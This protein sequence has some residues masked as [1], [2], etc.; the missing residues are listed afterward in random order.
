MA[1]K[2]NAGRQNEIA[3]NKEAHDLFMALKYINNG[4]TK[5]IQD[6]QSPIPIGALWNDN[7]KGLNILKINKA[8]GGW[9]PAFEGYYHP[10]NIKE[11]P[12]FPT[13][14]QIWI[15]ESQDSILK[16]YDQ[17]TNSWIATR[18]MQTTAENV[19]VDMHN[20]FINIF[21]LK[22][23]DEAEGK[24]TY[25]VPYDQY[26]KLFDN[27]LFI[28]PTDS[29]Y[30]KLSDVSVQYD[31]TSKEEQESWIHVNAHKVFKIEKKLIKIN[32]AGSE[33][34][35]VYGL[36]DN[37][38]ELYYLDESGQG[39]AMIPYKP[40][41][42][43]AYDYKAFNGGIEIISAKA[44]AATYIYSMSYVFQDT[45]NPGKLIRN[46]FTIGSQSEVQIGQLTKR[47]LIFLDGLYLEQTKYNY[48]SDT[49][50]V[51]INDT[52]IN[53]MD[54]MAVVFQDMESTG[55]KEIN[56]VT[57]P[58]T[59][60]LVGT[61]TNA[62][63]F[64]KPLAFVSGVMGTNVVSPEE[65]A[66]QGTSLVIK[67]WGLDT[68]EAPARVMVV[69]ADNMYLCHGNFDDSCII[70]NDGISNNP[71]D[72][73]LLFIDGLLM[74]SRELDVSE[75]QI[76]IANAKKGQQYVLLK[77]KD[78]SN[79]ALS[80]DN[81]VM[82]FTIAINNEDGTM[83]NECND[84]V[85]FADGKMIP[86]EDSV[87]RD[88]LPIR[89]SSGQIIKVKNKT[90]SSE[91]YN[92]Y[93]W[94]EDNKRWDI[95]SDM[96]TIHQITSFIKGNYSNGSI[97]LDSV[98]L[99][100][101]KGTYYAYTYSNGVEEP[102]LKGIQRL[103]RDQTEYAVNVEHM[104]N[105]NQGALSVY[106][107]K[108]LNFEVQEE[109]S[110]T[111]KFIIPILTSD[112][113][114]DPYENG[115]L[116]YYIERP[117]KNEIVSCEKEVL[118][119]ANRTMDFNGGYT[120]NIS[121]LPGVVNVYVNGVRLTRQDFTIVNEN[122]LIIHKQIVGNQNNYDPDNRDTWNKFLFYEKNETVSIEC[123]R[124]D[125]I[126]VEVRQDYNLK[127]QTIKSRYSGQRTFYTEDDG[128]PKSLLISQDLIK[129]F[130]DG[131]IY[132]G[133]YTINRESGSITLLDPS[134]DSIIGVDPIAR[135]FELNPLEY[136]EY[137]IEHGKPYV[138]NPIMNEITFE[139]R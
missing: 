48:H 54:M 127:S 73:Y 95:I 74:S 124:D 33:A 41:S 67:N 6:K 82:N 16:Y 30:H 27:G 136:E 138:S 117:E 9:V 51:Q 121:L 59:D 52:I 56:N 58:G 61:F 78:N 19:L 68:I 43:K 133:E 125:H 96:D 118:T 4:P 2:F 10:V 85:I 123:N 63:N 14:G 130:I 132:T 62:V 108:L 83:Y 119:A 72:E 110:N 84:A 11:K 13:D 7:G 47:P 64:K 70:T 105:N 134:L 5:P 71:N 115:E 44:K 135:Y 57:G 17:N 55:E 137:L 28:H 128:I 36:F 40:D 87:Y 129:I 106:T 53:P 50:K 15:D 88:K 49:G 139:W 35:R 93:S 109:S 90:L 22:D 38:T 46:D 80:F 23:M 42:L 99:E 8:N 92:Y 29:K 66:F 91:V 98:G 120:T 34:Y 37:N 112:E 107:N 65:I 20:N 24:K 102:L 111:G 94:D 12:L 101:K 76:R 25:L 75:H 77:I 3:L 97:M 69:E 81:K 126:L 26:G 104:F 116:L 131:V 100:Q 1:R 60:T 86:M 18:A 122:T 31:T 103:R 79:T 21:P 39:I 45:P 113:G 32:K 114:T 89:G